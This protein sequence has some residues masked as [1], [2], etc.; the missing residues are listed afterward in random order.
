MSVQTLY[1]WGGI[2]SLTTAVI[3]VIAAV[4]VATQP[5]SSPLPA[6]MYFVGL[7]VV[8]FA[9]TAV[10]V[11]QAQQAGK[12]GLAGFVLSVIGAML[13]SAP[14]YTL[15]AGSQGVAAWHDIWGFAMGNVLPVGASILLL[16]MIMLGAVTFRAAVFP[17]WS[18]A[19]LAIGALLWLI[20][21]WLT[22]AAALLPV[23]SLVIGLGLAWMGWTLVG[24]RLTA[25]APA[26]AAV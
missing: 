26:I 4:A 8:V 3:L 24:G 5:L 2:A 11:I 1:R 16:G 18:G 25:P 17:R 14:V 12:L 19:L 21:F 7:V 15:I 23:G 22:A 6:L 13:Y 20:A 9:L 10:Y